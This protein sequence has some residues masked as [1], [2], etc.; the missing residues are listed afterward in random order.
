MALARQLKDS[1]PR[2]TTIFLATG[3]EEV[4][5]LGSQYYVSTLAARRDTVLGAYILGCLN[6]DLLGNGQKG[7]VA[8][9]GKTY[10][11]LF[12]GIEAA[13]APDTWLPDIRPQGNRPNS[14][15]WPFTQAGI[16]A[17]FFFTEGGPPNYHDIYDTPDQIELPVFWRFS[18]LITS[19]L[20]Q[21]NL[22]ASFQP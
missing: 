21:P 14:D 6:F 4:G 15:H 11:K 1:P 3:A 8:V 7:V 19:F 18:Q 9:A 12:A 13:N 2:Y 10:P 22:S 5:L 17:L 20:H 16:P